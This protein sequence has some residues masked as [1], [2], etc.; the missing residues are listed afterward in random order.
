MNDDLA[1]AIQNLKEAELK[2]SKSMDESCRLFNL[3][4]VCRQ[5]IRRLT[6]LGELAAKIYI[7]EVTP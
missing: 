6:S 3:V 4:V 1:K 7:P 5:E 2:Y